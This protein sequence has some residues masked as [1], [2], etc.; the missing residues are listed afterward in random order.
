[1]T[2]TSALIGENDEFASHIHSSI[3]F[4]TFAEKSRAFTSAQCSRNAHFAELLARDVAKP[5]P[6]IEIT[7]SS[8][9]GPRERTD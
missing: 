7:G 6:A 3:A 2:F 8:P 1:M 9:S 4:R 5:A